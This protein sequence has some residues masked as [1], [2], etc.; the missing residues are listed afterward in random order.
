MSVIN[1]TTQLS[2]LDDTYKFNHQAVILEVI[3]LPEEEKSSALEVA[4]VLD[5][6]IFY[7]QGGGQS[8]D[9][10]TILGAGVGADT[11]AV[12]GAEFV[13]EAVSF[14]DGIVYHKGA[15]KSGEF[16]SGDTV[17]LNIDSELRMRNARLHSA[18]HLI[19]VAVRNLGL[20]IIPTKGYHFPDGPY[21][22]YTGELPP[23]DKEQLPDK[24]Q[25]ELNR[26]I[27]Q[28]G[29][30]K[31]Q[32]ANRDELAQLCEHVPD[33]LPADKPSRVVTMSTLGCPCGGTHVK[34]LSDLGAVA[35]T[36]VKT[37]GGKIRVSYS[38]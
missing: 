38:L 21:V 16:K 25:A 19:D 34:E 15:F 14:K 18:G 24:I 2:Y 22:E 37:K 35:I 6:T 17:E 23:C 29:T 26:L 7:P 27:A 28:G 8:S 33:Y 4:L 1:R 36:K 12:A 31:T 10:G 20:D 9:K 13:V 30:V 3:S 5:D 32:Y 11:D